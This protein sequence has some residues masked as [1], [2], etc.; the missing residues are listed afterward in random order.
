MDGKITWVVGIV[1]LS[2][3]SA[4]AVQLAYEPFNTPPYVVG[5][6]AGQNST[7][8]FFTG[9]WTN[10]DPASTNSTIQATGLTYLG[11]PSLGGAEM[12]TPN[13]T[14][15]LA[16]TTPW[17]ATTTG[18]YYIGY[19]MS[20]GAGN[21]ADGT[22]GND[23]GYRAVEFRAADNT[24]QF[25]VAYN[26][27]NG[28]AG[29]VN[30][31]PRTGRMVLDTGA[32]QII[33]GSPTSFVADN[34]VTHLIVLKLVLSA[35]AAADS[36]SLYLDP[37]SLAEPLIPNA[38]LSNVDLSLGRIGAATIFGGSGTF[39]VFDELRVGT[40]YADV[41][42]ALPYPGDT[43]GDGDVDLVDYQ[44]IFD[45]LGLRGQST[46]NGDIAKG[47]GTQ[48]VDGV[49]DMNDFHLWK[50]NYPHTPGAGASSDQ[51]PE[52]TTLL[53]VFMGAALSGIYAMGFR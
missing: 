10:R 12:S 52:P 2:T 21:Y 41:L 9:A 1:L 19:E 31:D 18:T 30:Q 37:T 29:S 7:G 11:S 13:S 27:Y 3:S 45:H 6:L 46:L 32:L 36:L 28:N 49:V 38:S 26:A 50:L 43:D 20:F 44:H 48:G 42:P 17:D 47:D 16:L 8:P 34:G 24:F 35:T 5:P 39:P 25:G 33:Q 23:M 4:A 53:L 22:D 51:A 40:T 15:Q 14:P